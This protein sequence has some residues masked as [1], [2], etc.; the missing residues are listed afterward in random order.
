MSWQRLDSAY[1]T[2]RL[3]G[4]EG[5]LLEDEDLIELARARS[6]TDF[7]AKLRDT[8]YPAALRNTEKHD[9]HSIEIAL[10]THLKNRQE[11]VLEHSPKT[12][13]PLLKL[14]ISRNEIIFIKDLIYS[15]KEGAGSPRLK[16]YTFLLNTSLWKSHVHLLEAPTIDE[17]LTLLKDTRYHAPLKKIRDMGDET[18][19]LSY[20]IILDRLYY[21]NLLT[22]VDKLPFNEK[23]H[24]NQLILHETDCANLLVYLR[25][26]KLNLSFIDY[27]IPTKSPF[28]KKLKNLEEQHRIS[29]LLPMLKL[30]E[31]LDVVSSHVKSNDV[32]SLETELKS[33]V[34]SRNKKVFLSWSDGADIILA[35]LKLKEMEVQSLWSIAA[36]L[37]N[38]LPTE[39]IRQALPV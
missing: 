20:D 22:E 16:D 39:R 10:L 11:F 4:L 9:I 24:A 29:E 17:L 23:K 3:R 37:H 13:Y 19:P 21:E 15:K 28:Y 5:R 26:I 30:N 25:A 8:E 38:G 35:Y 31:R 12:L 18:K 36:G 33:I 34:K 1:L 14:R 7:T 32:K 27:S 2:T 6:L